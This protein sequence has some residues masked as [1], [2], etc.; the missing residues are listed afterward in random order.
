MG[1]GGGLG[2]TD[3]ITILRSKLL[4]SAVG[5]VVCLFLYSINE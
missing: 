2:H 1:G 4:Q 5:I 3:I